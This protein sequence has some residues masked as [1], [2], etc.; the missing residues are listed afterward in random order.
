MNKNIYSISNFGTITHYAHFF[1]ALLI[2]LIYYDIKTEGKFTYNIKIDIGSNIKILKLIFPNRIKK[3]YIKKS[4]SISDK[5]NYYDLYLKLLKNENTN[6]ILLD[7]FDIFKNNMYE[8]ITKNYSQ[9]EFKKLENEYINRIK[10]N[11][12]RYQ[13]LYVTNK[14]IKLKKIRPYIINFFESKIKISSPQIILIDR[15]FMNKFNKNIFLNTSGQRRIIYNHDELKNILSKL[16]KSNFLNISLDNLDIYNQYNIFRNA[17]IIIGQHGAGLCNLFFCKKSTLIEIIPEWGNN[18][19]K[20]YASFC[21]IKY[22]SINQ[23]RMTKDEWVKFNN[24]YKLANEN[25]NDLFNNLD[26]NKNRLDDSPIINFIKSSGSVNINDII[27]KVEQAKKYYN[28]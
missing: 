28:I 12:Q 3:K 10:T 14:Y 25:T 22:I 9:T 5:F 2:P 18:W 6:D 24:I 23:P 8:R 17:K 15:P 13:E 26:N 16:Y 20:N 21:K 7:A 27:D 11:K 1:Y 4:E 19:F